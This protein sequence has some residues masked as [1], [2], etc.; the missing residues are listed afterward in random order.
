MAN[1]L[2]IIK[3]AAVEAVEASN[4]AKIMYGTVTAVSPLAIKIDQRFTVTEAFLIL[5]KNVRDYE[6]EITLDNWVTENKSGGSGESS[7]ASHGHE[8]NGKKKVTIH[9]ALKTGDKVILLREQG[10]QKYVVIDKA[11]G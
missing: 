11:G 6:V 1:L 5:T 2:Q 8:I 4:P 7:F 10:G 3:K 9:N